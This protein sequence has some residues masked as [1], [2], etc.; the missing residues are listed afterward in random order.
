MVTDSAHPA[1]LQVLTLLVK[2]V[3]TLVVRDSVWR[4]FEMPLKAECG[5]AWL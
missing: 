5:G 2:P 1:R 3:L 4:P